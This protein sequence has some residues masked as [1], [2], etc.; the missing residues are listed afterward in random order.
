MA[1][2]RLGTGGRFDPADMGEALRRPS[3][4]LHPKVRDWVAEQTD[5]PSL[6]RLANRLT[7]DKDSAKVRAFSADIARL[8]RLVAA[9]AST[10]QL[11]QALTTELGLAGAVATL[12]DGRYGM[13]RSAQSDDLSALAHIAQLIP[14]PSLFESTIRKQLSVPR[15]PVR[16]AAVD[17]APGKGPR[18]AIRGRAPRRRR[19]VSS[20][21][22]RQRRR[23]AAPVSRSDHA[24]ESPRHHR[25]RRHTEPVHRRTH[26]RT[27]PAACRVGC[28]GCPAGGDQPV[29]RSRRRLLARS[30]IDL[31]TH[32]SVAT[33]STRFQGWSLSIRATSG[34][35]CR[36]NRKPPLPNAERPCGVSRSVQQWRPGVVSEGSS[37][38]GPAT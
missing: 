35:L 31:T 30:Q 21:P 16:G 37:V 36:S 19:P 24:H 23:G 4:G 38:L 10:A 25:G 20:S 15:S 14:E 28:C 13:N 17:R 33:T 29:P 34:Q 22:R 11:V 32:W 8:Q 2:L 12:D 27:V 5:L 18:M 3:R 7:N 1:W 26:H 6:E 9:R